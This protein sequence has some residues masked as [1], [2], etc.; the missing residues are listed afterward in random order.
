[1]FSLAR[2]SCGVFACLANQ[3]FCLIIL[4]AT[5]FVA[6]TRKRATALLSLL[7]RA[8]GATCSAAYSIVCLF[9]L[10]T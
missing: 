3:S 4:D 1:M 5:A 8:Y 7:A 9:L 10:H 2:C 6:F